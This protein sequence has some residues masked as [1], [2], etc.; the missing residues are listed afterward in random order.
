MQILLS[1]TIFVFLIGGFGVELLI[2][3]PLLALNVTE[4]VFGLWQ[5]D[6]VGKHL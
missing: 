2:D 3:Q 5:A 4:H 6:E 1:V